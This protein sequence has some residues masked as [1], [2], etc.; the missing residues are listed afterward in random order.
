MP[1]RGCPVC[2]R[3]S[4]PRRASRGEGAPVLSL[5]WRGGSLEL[6]RRGHPHAHHRSG[7]A[8]PRS[9]APLDRSSRE[10][11]VAF[12]G[13]LM[14]AVPEAERPELSERPSQD[15]RGAARAAAG[16]RQRSG[17]NSSA[18]SVD[19]MM[20]VDDESF[21]VEG[22]MRSKDVDVVRLTA[23]SPEG[24]RAELDRPALPMRAP[25]R[26]RVLRAPRRSARRQAGFVCF[27]ETEAPSLRGRRLDLRARG[28]ARDGRSSSR[29]HRSSPTR[30][31]FVRRSSRARR[32][33]GSPT[34]T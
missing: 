22:W 1:R 11:V 6:T 32:S 21:Y 2:S 18:R 14:A 27:F 4:C 28:C 9:L 3:P 24:H 15:S 23:V 20:G 25:R 7:S 29:H 19:R 13:S 30:P 16:P 12:L 10:K 33:T 8:R 17:E 26:D 5:E 31:R 34:T